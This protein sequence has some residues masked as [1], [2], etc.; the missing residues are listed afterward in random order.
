MGLVKLFWQICL[1]QKG[2]QDVPSSPFF[3]Q[4]MMIVYVVVSFLFLIIIGGSVS[5]SL[6]YAVGEIALLYVCV[7]SLL[8]VVGFGYRYQQTLVAVLGTSLL[9][10]SMV[11]IAFVWLDNSVPEDKPEALR[12]IQGVISLWS[13]VVTGHIYRHALQ[14]ILFVGILLGFVTMLFIAQILFSLTS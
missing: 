9:L 14:T 12:M 4:L 11:V 2:P 3:F 13:F 6:I 7:R 10:S 8:A 5:Y 1:L